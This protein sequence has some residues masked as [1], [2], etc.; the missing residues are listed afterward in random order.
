MSGERVDLINLYPMKPDES[1]GAWTDRLLH[2]SRI[3]GTYRQCSIGWHGE[4]SQ[5]HLGTEGECNCICHAPEDIRSPKPE[6]GGRRVEISWWHTETFTAT[7][8]VDDD[9]ELENLDADEVL[10]GIICNMDQ[11][12]LSRAFTGCTER[13]ITSKKE[14]TNDQ[15]HPQ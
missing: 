2:L 4:C 5:R 3:H 1:E 15:V 13:E 14:V 10:D 11:A 8:E 9:F 12:E 7:V 6:T